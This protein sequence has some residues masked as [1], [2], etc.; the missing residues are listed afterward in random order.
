MTAIDLTEKLD[1]IRD[2]FGP[3]YWASDE[4]QQE[5]IALWDNPPC[6]DCGV[7]ESRE[8]IRIKLDGTRWYGEIDIAVAPSGW[9]AISI[10]WWYGLGGGGSAPSVWNRFAYTSHDEAV[11]AGINQLV[12]KFEGIRD[13][14]GWTPENHPALA[15]RMID[16]LKDHLSQARQMTL[17]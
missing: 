1:D 15:Q 14:K 6:N 16:A 4:A 13:M 17:F 2:R 7:F 9:H 10:S 12:A 8:T 5:M 3:R 11:A